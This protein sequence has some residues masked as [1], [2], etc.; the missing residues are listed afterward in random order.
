MENINVCGEATSKD[1]KPKV[2]FDFIPAP[3]SD[4]DI[5]EREKIAEEHI[6]T[7][8]R[9][10][11]WG[12]LVPTFPPAQI[13]PGEDPVQWQRKRVIE[14]AK[15]YVG[16]PYQHHHIPL[17]VCGKTG[18]G[19]DCSNYTSWVYNFGLG[20]RFTSHCQK[21]AESDESKGRKLEP[22]EKLEPGDLLFILRGDR[23]YISH[24][25]IYIGDGKIID[26]GK[27]GVQIRDY[28]G[29][30][31]SHHTFTRRMIE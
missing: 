9:H 3:T 27:G 23:S 6:K 2:V 11:T 26:S 15:R 10:D 30:Y 19:I 13:P 22:D 24:V 12:P 17:W 7:I 16:L 8:K 5:L 21:Q 25:V 14:I 20:M 4:P 29:W 18:Q 1:D 31:K 28:A